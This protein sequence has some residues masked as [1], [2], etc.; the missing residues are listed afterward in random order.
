MWRERDSEAATTC[1]SHLIE[2]ERDLALMCFKLLLK[3]DNGTVRFG[4]PSN[5]YS[6]LSSLRTVCLHL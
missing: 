6:V 1:C 4:E 3:E 5:I 2:R